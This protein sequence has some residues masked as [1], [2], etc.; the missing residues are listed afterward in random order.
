MVEKNNQ[1]NDEQKINLEDSDGLNIS[2]IVGN[3]GED[4]D[5]KYIKKLDDLEKEI[6]IKVD[7]ANLHFSNKMKELINEKLEPD[8]KNSKIDALLKEHNQK[9][10]EIGKEKDERKDK[11]KDEH[12][13]LSQT[14]SL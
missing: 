5:R 11:L 1:K 9:L 10:M 6:Q 3:G 4:I 12:Q 7:N 13:K 14:I 8:A 2:G